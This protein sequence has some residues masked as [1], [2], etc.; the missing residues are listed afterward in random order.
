VISRR[1]PCGP[2]SVMF[3]L[4]TVEQAAAL[5][6]QLCDRAVPGVIEVVPGARTVLV[7]AQ[8]PEQLMS[9][10]QIVA[11]LGAGDVPTPAGEL[12]D[13]PTV[14]DGVDLVDVAGRT[15]LSVADVVDMHSTVEYRAAFSGFT[16]G[17]TYLT[18]LAT[19]L[20]LPRRSVPRPRVDAGSVAIGADFTGVYPTASPGG[21]HL[22][23]HATVEMWNPSRTRP[24][25]IVAGDRVRFV[26]VSE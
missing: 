1:L 25:F 9:I 12:V 19:A 15:G 10:D 5:A 14:Y 17:F 11:A 20:W 22:L 3:E 24:A 23:G 13:V 21:W 2:T 26:P 18:G 4:D 6:T 7:V 8:R 16:P